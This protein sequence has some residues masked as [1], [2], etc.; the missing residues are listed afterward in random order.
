[1]LCDRLPWKISK[2]SELL[3]V[4]FDFIGNLSEKTCIISNVPDIF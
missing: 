2:L 3:V 1:M 4:F